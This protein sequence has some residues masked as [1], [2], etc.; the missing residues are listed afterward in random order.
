MELP[1]AG[2]EGTSFQYA[3]VAVLSLRYFGIPARYAEGYVIS[4]EMAEDY[5]GGETMTVDSSCAAAWTE[6]YQDGIGWIPM[7]LTPG[8]GETVKGPG[9]DGENPGEGTNP[10][11]TDKQQEEEETAEE[12]E[13]NGGTRVQIILEAVL[14]GLLT[15]LAVLALI[16][17][18]LW[19]R[20]KIL[21]S[22]KMKKFRMENCPD[23]VSWIYA[24]TAL[25]LEKLGFDWGNG[26]MRS[27]KEPLER[28]FGPDYASQFELVTDLNDRALFSSRPM[29]EDDRN[30]ALELRTQTLQQLNA[31]LKWYRRLALKWLGCLY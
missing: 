5:A 14:K 3:T 28:K 12:P 15:F 23:A 1:L 11:T 22:R 30:A 7:D 17:L 6:V 29:S 9:G 16:F 31:H 4:E 26:S 13:P 8:M 21:I 24:D 25:L 19:I 20:R 18:A 27:L 10:N 2:V